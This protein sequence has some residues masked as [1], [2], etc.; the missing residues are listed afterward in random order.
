MCVKWLLQLEHNVARSSCDGCSCCS[1]SSCSCSC[2]CSYI[3]AR[4]GIP[5]LVACTDELSRSLSACARKSAISKSTTESCFGSSGTDRP[6]A[7]ADDER[8]RCRMMK[9]RS[10]ASSTAP[11][12]HGAII[13]ESGTPR[14]GDV[15]IGARVGVR[16]GVRVDAG[17]GAGVGASVGAGVGAGVVGDGVGETVGE[18]VGDVVAG[19][20][21]TPYCGPHSHFDTRRQTAHFVRRSNQYTHSLLQG[22]AKTLCPVLVLMIP[23]YILPWIANLVSGMSRASLGCVVFWCHKT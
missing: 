1:C 23:L 17:V 10:S 4:G 12:N 7:V 20:P 22:I 3:M 2:S 16:V 15:R 18:A 13:S 11:V 8:F 21:Q 19:Q 9:S 5:L 14:L 6:R